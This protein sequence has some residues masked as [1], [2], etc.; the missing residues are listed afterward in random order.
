MLSQ[1]DLEPL[2]KITVCGTPLSTILW[3][4]L[5]HPLEFE[6]MFSAEALCIDDDKNWQMFCQVKL[7]LGV[8]DFIIG[9]LNSIL[10]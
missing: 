6:A 10:L 4:E 1:L 8:L 2:F 7:I 5:E 3:K 9:L